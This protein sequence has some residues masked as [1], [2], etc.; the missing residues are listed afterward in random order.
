ML[1]E[2]FGKAKD[3][4]CQYLFLLQIKY[5]FFFLHLYYYY[6]IVVTTSRLLVITKNKIQ[7]VQWIASNDNIKQDISFQTL[8][9]PQTRH[10]RLKND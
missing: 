10:E 7:H 6:Y 4:A 8:G 5:W 3:I 1:V 2:M 9:A